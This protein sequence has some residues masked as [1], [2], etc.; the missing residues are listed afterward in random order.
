[1]TFV[2]WYQW[3]IGS[4]NLV[5]TPT[6]R[7]SSPLEKVVHVAQMQN[8]TAQEPTES[9]DAKPVDAMGNCI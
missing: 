9:M 3:G 7:C 5:D 6:Y 2:S 1:M 4:R 8:D